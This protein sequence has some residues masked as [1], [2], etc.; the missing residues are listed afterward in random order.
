MKAQNL[1]ISVPYNGCDKGCPYC[2][3]HM[4]GIGEPN[5]NLM[6]S[7]VQKVRTLAKHAEVTSV[8]FTGK[9]EPFLSMDYFKILLKE[10]REFPC[11]VQTNGIF[12]NK[13]RKDLVEDLAIAG[14]NVV[15][16]SIDD[17]SYFA[18]Y[19]DLF[20]QLKEAGIVVRVALNVWKKTQHPEGMAHYIKLC[21]EHGVQQFLLRNITIP[22]GTLPSNSAAAW[23]RENVDKAFYASAVSKFLTDAK[24][25]GAP[26][27]RKLRANSQGLTVWD[28]E[29]VSVVTSDYCIQDSAIDDEIRSLIFQDDGH[30]YTAWNSLASILF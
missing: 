16:V 22:T 4:T 25:D 2:V 21:R 29:G 17:C 14:L 12:L 30:L 20:R 7:N 6:L 1:T 24:L 3:S 27:I 18:Y 28:Y 26:Y 23:I 11:E 5:F 15:A 19:A 8:L 10:F 9:G 13:N